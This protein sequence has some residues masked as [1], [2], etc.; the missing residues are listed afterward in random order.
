[1]SACSKP[2]RPEIELALDDHH[3]SGDLGDHAIVFDYGALLADVDLAQDGGGP[4]G[5]M[6][7]A[8][9]PECG[10][11]LSKL[12]LDVATGAPAGPQSVFRIE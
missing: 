10:Q 1:M 3:A 2:N 11:M 12:G 4:T 7:G 8:D 9:D 5:C 6:S